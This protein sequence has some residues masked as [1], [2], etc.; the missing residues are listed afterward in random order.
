[1]KRFRLKKKYAII[2]LVL[3]GLALFTLVLGGSYAFFTQQV[4]SK[5]YIVYTGNLQVD[6]T[7]TGNL[8]NLT[9]AYPK[10]NTEGLKETGYTFNITNNGNINARYQIRLEL[11]STSNMPLEYVKMAYIRTKSN[12][13]QTDEE[14]EPILLSNLN[15]T[16]TFISNKQI[17]AGKEDSYNLKLWIDYNAPNDVQGKKFKATIVVD[18]LQ[19]VEDGYV[20]GDTAPIITL[21]KYEDGNT[22]SHILVNGQF[23]DPGIL[24]VKDDKDILTQEDVTITVDY[25]ADGNNLT[26]V[27]AVDPTTAGIYY[28]NYSVTDSANNTTTVVR[29][30]T[31][32]LAPTIPTIS[33]IGNNSITIDQYSTFT[34]PGVTVTSG[35]HVA[36]IGEVKTIAPGSYT[37]RYIV[38]DSNGSVNSVVRTVVVNE[39]TVWDFEFDPDND[40]QGQEQIFTV[41]ANGKYKLE[42][43]GAQGGDAD[44][45]NIGGYG[46]YTVGVSNLQSSTT[47]Y[48]YVG[49]SGTIYN[50]YTQNGNNISAPGYNGGG[51]GGVTSAHSAWP[52]R[53]FASGGGATH[54]ALVTGKLSEIEEY[55]GV[56]STNQDYYISDEI[57]IVAA[58]GGGGCYQYNTG[59]TY[60]KWSLG[61]SGGGY[62][63]VNENVTYLVWPAGSNAGKGATQTEPGHFIDST[64]TN[65]GYFGQGIMT[66]SVLLAGNAING[67][68]GG[69]FGGSIGSGG[70]GYIASS[71]LNSYGNITKHMACYNCTG[72]LLSDNSET[73]TIT[74][75]GVSNEPEADNAKSGNG[76]ARITYLGN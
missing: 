62:K 6:Y 74:A 25:T 9:K 44:S 4:T 21:N 76:Y 3:G 15:N 38:I 39:K 5:D 1:M 59:K 8:I 65:D 53:Y 30:V 50:T 40:G 55:K 32:N 45:T 16:L 26:Q 35:N 22:D 66:E 64:Y 37:I 63:G 71:N 72:D 10:T 24:S 47:L 43:W 28:I 29:V 13:N 56:L 54:I 51:Y 46:A 17:E 58:G 31:V 60:E 49:G 69:F 67:G 12:S 75:L 57:L 52:Y 2:L 18:S 36:T 27:Q 34:D 20:M 42:V 73:K 7:R 41:P 11:D 23:T 19:D 68:G 33:L 61:G 14:I 48:I 70:S